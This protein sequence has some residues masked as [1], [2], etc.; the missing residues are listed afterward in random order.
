MDYFDKVE[1]YIVN[2]TINPYSLSTGIVVPTLSIATIIFS[3]FL[4][5]TIVGPGRIPR[6]IRI[7]LINILIGVIVFAIV[8]LAAAVLYYTLYDCLRNY[9]AVFRDVILKWNSFFQN[10]LSP[11]CKA[12]NIT[13]CYFDNSTAFL[14][15]PFFEGLY[16]DMVAHEESCDDLWE[17]NYRSFLGLCFYGLSTL[18][19]VRTLFMAFYA[20]LVYVFITSIQYKIKIWAVV[21]GCVGI[22]VF[23]II[24][25]IGS[26]ILLIHHRKNL[27][28]FIV[29]R[30]LNIVKEFISGAELYALTVPCIIGIV[31]FIISAVFPILAL[32]F[33]KKNT[34][35]G[36]NSNDASYSKATAKLALFLMA[37][38]TF[39]FI[40]HLAVIVP[41]LVFRYRQNAA[42]A[43]DPELLEFEQGQELRGLIYVAFIAGLIIDLASLLFTPILFTIFLRQIRQNT[44]KLFCC[45]LRKVPLTSTILSARTTLKSITLKSIESTDGE[46]KHNQWSD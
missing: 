21:L 18:V 12:H 33:L 46:K 10:V 44:K 20:I 6:A 30:D 15:R 25:N 24:V 28:K 45:L 1:A 42:L 17:H 4:I 38:N 5:F 32:R 11:Y 14:D 27:L 37:G 8:G 43:A 34:G 31:A 7:V 29:D 23:A 41:S 35:I 19:S 9:N 13:P 36:V 22:W 26:I 40:G 39:S 16:T 2:G 3:T